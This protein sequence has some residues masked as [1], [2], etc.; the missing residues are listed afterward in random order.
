MKPHLLSMWS[1]FGRL[2]PVRI[3]TD[4]VKL[5]KRATS[6]TMRGDVKCLPHES[7]LEV[8]REAS[9]YPVANVLFNPIME[10]QPDV[11]QFHYRSEAGLNEN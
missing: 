4:T 9:V 7:V 11:P 2:S 3:V 8:G 10:V 1:K 6:R 5:G